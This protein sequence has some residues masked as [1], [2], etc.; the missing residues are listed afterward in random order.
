MSIK[1]L[2]NNYVQ[3]ENQIDRTEEKL[4]A[5]EDRHD[6]KLLKLIQDSKLYLH[7]LKNK[8]EEL[9][10]E[11]QEKSKE[12]E[13]IR[14][15]LNAEVEEL[16]NIYESE[17]KELIEDVQDFVKHFREAY[18]VIYN[19]LRTKTAQVKR[20]QRQLTKVDGEVHSEHYGI[21]HDNLTSELA[22]ALK[23]TGLKVV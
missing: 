9:Q 22:K 7:T 15:L 11:L 4:K 16:S 8:K 13:S 2:K 10:N 23:E 1:L 3:V 17:A 19:K 6:L 5:L 18:E 20:L 12:A 21:T 14:E